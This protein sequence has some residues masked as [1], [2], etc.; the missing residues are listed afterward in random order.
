M[1]EERVCNLKV[2]IQR[3]ADG[4]IRTDV[5]PNWTYNEFWW[6]DGNAGCDCNRLLF[7]ERAEKKEV[8]TSKPICGSVAFKVRLSDNDSNEVLYDEF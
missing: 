8:K 2:E 5:W 6:T 7:F 4:V 1:S 3:V